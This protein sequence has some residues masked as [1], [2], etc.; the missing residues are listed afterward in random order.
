[1]TEKIEKSRSLTTYQFFEIVQIEYICALLRSR[2]Y[3]RSKDKQYWLRVPEG[4]KQK[5]E[6]ISIRN[7]NMANIFTD[8]DMLSALERRIYRENTYPIFIYKDDIHRS[9]QEY[10]DMLCYYSKGAEVRFD[11]GNGQEIG[12]IVN[13]KPFDESAS[14]QLL[15][16]KE[17]IEV[18]VIYLARVL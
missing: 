15:Q 2:I 18:P 10:F 7:N 14:V 9:T 4:K 11:F 12:Q 8:S 1:M 3:T 6:E 13:Y 16:T 17:I 5:I